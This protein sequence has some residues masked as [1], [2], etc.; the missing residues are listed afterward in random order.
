MKILDSSNVQ[1]ESGIQ[2]SEIVVLDSVPLGERATGKEIE[3]FLRMSLVGHPFLGVTRHICNSRQA[4]LQRL[5]ELEASAQV[6]RIPIIHI[7]C[8][9][10]KDVGLEFANK[11]KLAWHELADALNRINLSTGFNLLVVISA[12]FGA[13]LN[14][15][16]DVRKPCPC[17]G[18]IAPTDETGPY[19]LEE[20]F[21][22]FYGELFKRW[23]LHDAIRAL[24][25]RDLATGAWHSQTAE[26]WFWEVVL[27]YL[28]GTCR[29]EDSDRWALEIRAERE[30]RGHPYMALR[31]IKTYLRQAH[32]ERLRE[33]FEIYFQT[34]SSLA[35]AEKFE[36]FRLM[37][38]ETLRSMTASG[39]YL[40]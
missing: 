14:T 31:D 37:Y 22:V 11:E 1:M 3:D 9:G 4:F 18:V 35:I 10:G 24:E 39:E 25:A 7:E 15:L 6:G 40:L 38:V 19:E 23:N 12:C 13:Y 5:S 16:W 26:D 21:T 33:Y 17:W 29:I 20:G 32:Q 27:G 2:F 34:A 28:N 8:H 36:E 30:S